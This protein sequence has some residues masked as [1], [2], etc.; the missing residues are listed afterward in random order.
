MPNAAI[1]SQRGRPAIDSRNTAMS[2]DERRRHL[3]DCALHPLVHSSRF[4]SFTDRAQA[5]QYAGAARA[6]PG[7]SLQSAISFAEG[8]KSL[9]T[10]FLLIGRRTECE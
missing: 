6:Q 9:S 8:L 7:S 5:N 4:G 1:R 10:G 3:L 2:D